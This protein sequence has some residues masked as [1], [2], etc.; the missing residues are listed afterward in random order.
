MGGQPCIA[1]IAYGER[2]FVHELRNRLE[3]AT[4]NAESSLSIRRGHGSVHITEAAAMARLQTNLIKMLSRCPDGKTHF[5]SNQLKSFALEEGT[6][7]AFCRCRPGSRN[8]AEKINPALNPENP[9][10]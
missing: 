8:P 9:I 2:R 5:R 6:A 7:L 3:A 4:G 10:R 1:K